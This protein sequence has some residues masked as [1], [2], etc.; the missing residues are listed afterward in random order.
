M[1]LNLIEQLIGL[2]TFPILILFR[3]YF[4]FIRLQY[5]LML[6]FIFEN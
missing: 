2:I 5:K 3:M 1:K 6:K 4:V